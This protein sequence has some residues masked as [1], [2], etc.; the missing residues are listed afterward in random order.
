MAALNLRVDLCPVRMFRV[1]G[2]RPKI[3]EVED[4]GIECEECES[5]DLNL[6]VLPRLA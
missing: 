6:N 2:L 5:D 4:S 1:M 3:A